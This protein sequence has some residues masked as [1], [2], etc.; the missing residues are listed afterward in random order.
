MNREETIMKFYVIDGDLLNTLIDLM[1]ESIET[2][3]ELDMNSKDNVMYFT[4]LY[5]ELLELPQIKNARK[6]AQENK[7][8]LLK[9]KTKDTLSDKEIKMLHYL[10]QIMK[11]TDNKK[12][13][14][15]MSNEGRKII[16][17][18]ASKMKNEIVEKMS[19]GEIK[20]YLLDDPE[21]TD[22]ER[23]ELYYQEHD[24]INQEKQ[25]K[26][27]EKNST[28]YDKMLKDLGLNPSNT[29]KT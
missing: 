4:W 20:E 18:E 3:A 21:L 29:G 14:K 19:L 24:R 25:R 17:E 5:D 13:T 12:P 9:D 26:K 7:D 11:A 22:E 10:N 16:K 1:L 6:F 8:K 15:P 2:S 28:S 27:E 23:F